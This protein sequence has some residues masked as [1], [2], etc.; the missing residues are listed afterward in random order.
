MLRH[1]PDVL[2]SL[3]CPCSIRTDG[4]VLPSSVARLREQF[5]RRVDD[6]IARRRFADSQRLE[7][8]LAAFHLG[9]FGVAQ[10]VQEGAALGNDFTDETL[11][12]SPVAGNPAGAGASG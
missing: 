5:V 7:M 12:G 4:R 9:P 11:P 2:G 10:I 1:L 3:T 6:T 8:R